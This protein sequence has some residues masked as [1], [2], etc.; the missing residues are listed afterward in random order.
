MRSA[1][2]SLCT[3][4]LLL[5]C[6]ILSSFHQ[7]P[8][9]KAHFSFPYNEAGLTEHQAAAHLLSRFTFGAKPGDVAALVNM[10]LENWFQ[11]QLEAKLPDENL[12]QKFSNYDALKL[13]STEVVNAYVKGVKV[14]RMAIKEGV[15]D[16]NLVNKANKAAYKTALTAYMRQKGL[17]PQK[18]LFR[19][20][21]NQKILRAAYSNNQLQEMLTDFWFN[22]FNVSITKNDCA[23]FIPAYERDV[24]RPNA[25]GKFED[26]LLATAKSP[27]ML[28]YLDNFSST[29]ADT[30][31]NRKGNNLL[32]KRTVGLQKR[33]GDSAYEKLSDRLNQKKK[34]AGLN[35]NYAREV[36]ELHT[37][38]VDGGYTQ[39]D[40]T[41][42][43]RALTGWTVYPMSD[44]GGS[45]AIRKVIDRIGEDRLAEHGF[46]HD[47]DFLFAEN[48]HDKGSKVVL[49]KTFPQAVAIRKAYSY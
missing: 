9:G 8:K 38:G 36:M 33:L 2:A 34:A 10:G 28:M 6:N 39:S 17:K 46:V 27:A 11:Q 41:Q 35:E 42:A 1:S 4:A 40:V 23:E 5:S 12:N 15:I 31:M 7:Q 44:Y 26:L 29:G 48:R 18:E 37:L 13:S 16:K 25:L 21:A 43:A 19:Q 32:R 47:G 24:I 3:L 49:G 45:N 30:T 14:L 22:H 20:F